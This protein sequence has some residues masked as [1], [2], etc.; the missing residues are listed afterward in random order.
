MRL[1]LKCGV[2]ALCCFFSCEEKSPCTLSEA[3]MINVLTD[4]HIAEAASQSLLG[5]QK[6]S[7]L[8]EYYQQ[9]YEIHGVVEAQFKECYSELQA[10]PDALKLLLDSVLA[11]IDSLEMDGM[12]PP[13]D[14]EE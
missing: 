2:L 4:I 3:Q 7:L 5:L 12:V 11:R 8:N 1:F 13:D 14:E 10:N 9:V 6:D